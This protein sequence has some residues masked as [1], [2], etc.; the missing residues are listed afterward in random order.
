MARRFLTGI[1]LSGNKITNSADPSDAGDLVN[2][3]YV[4]NFVRGL[5]WGKPVVAA[6]T[7]NV[8]L[9]EPGAS[10]DGVSLAEDDRILLKD[11]TNPVQN[12][13]YEFVAS[14]EPLVRAVDM[15][16]ETEIR[17]GRATTVISGTTHDNSVFI[18]ANDDVF[19]IVGVSE[20]VFVQLGGGGTV[21]T[22]GNGLALS[23]GVFSVQL[24][25]NSGLTVNGSGLAVNSNIAGDGLDF[26]AGVLD[27]SIGDHLEFNAGVLEVDTTDLVTS[28][29]TVVR[30]YAANVPNGNT[31]AVVT[32]NLG[33]RDVSVTVYENDGDY[34]QVYPDIE[35]T[36]TNS[37]TLIFSVAPTSGEFRVVVHG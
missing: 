28:P 1:D 34:E 14:D 20:L 27:L 21:Y 16:H 2:L 18:L 23:D 25:S 5:S 24:Q 13:I 17:S 11:Q 37:V 7:G 33:T 6:S 8:N 30:K 12:G 10:L 15:A 35:H 9:S 19:V 3:G 22:A 4:Q 36:T 31:S 32:H 26:N 29:N